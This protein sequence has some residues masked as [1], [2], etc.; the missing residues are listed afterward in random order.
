LRAACIDLVAH[1]E[2]TLAILTPNLEPELY[3]HASFLDTLKR[4]VLARSFTRVRI[5]IT[6]P[7]RTI[8]PG[9]QLFQMGQRLSSYMEFRNLSSELRPEV[10]A[11]CIAD[12][13]AILYR[14]EYSSGEGMLAFR[15]PEIAQLYLNEFDQMWQAS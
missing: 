6:E 5:L 15:A 13:Q 9:N 2:R 7:E 12:N 8:R 4:L 1:T 14:A 3:E 10:R 11:F